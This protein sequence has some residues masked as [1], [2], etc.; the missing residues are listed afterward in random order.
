MS[1]SPITAVHIHSRYAQHPTREHTALQ[2][3][4]CVLELHRPVRDRVIYRCAP[5]EIEWSDVRLLTKLT[6]TLESRRNGHQS[7]FDNRSTFVVVDLPETINTPGSGSGVI[8]RVSLIS[9]SQPTHDWKASSAPENCMPWNLTGV[10][11]LNSRQLL[12]GGR[13][14]R[15]CS[16]R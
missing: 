7:L 6:L 12:P 10:V 16:M 3:S 11:A 8:I 13:F 14:S 15:R 9:S 4:Q 2:Q 1:Y 5:L